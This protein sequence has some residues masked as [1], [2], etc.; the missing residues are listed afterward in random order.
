MFIADHPI[1][2]PNLDI[3]PSGLLL[4]QQRLENYYYGQCRL[5]V[6]LVF[7]LVTLQKMYLFS[8]DFYSGSTLSLTKMTRKQCV[9]IGARP[10]VLV[11]EYVKI[12]NVCV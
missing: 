12:F 11:C 2:Q 4:S 1:S 8:D 6:I 9:N 3:S 7:M 10:Y 5:C